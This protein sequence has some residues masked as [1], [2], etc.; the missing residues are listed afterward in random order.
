[1]RP[2]EDITE[3][4]DLHVDDE[5]KEDKTEVPE[6]LAKEDAELTE[7]KGFGFVHG[8]GKYFRFIVQE[9]VYSFQDSPCTHW[10]GDIWLISKL[11]VVEAKDISE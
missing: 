5:T 3:Q 4:V 11:E 8:A 6:H 7:I 10:G 2:P 1:M 9:V